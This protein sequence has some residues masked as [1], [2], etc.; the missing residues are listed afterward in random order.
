M[1]L[2]DPEK[3]CAVLIGASAYGDPGLNEL[4]AVTNNVTR[5]GELL[6]DHDVWGL[7][8]ERCIRVPEPK[9]LVELLDPIHEAARAATDTL[10]VYFAGH[11]LIHPTDINTLLLALPTT[12]PPRPYT[13]VDFAQ[14]R[15]VVRSSAPNVNR[16]V[17]LDCCYAGRAF[18]GGMNGS[19]DEV[20]LAQQARIG[21]RTCSPHAPPPG[22]L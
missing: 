5:L 10:F 12:N 19:S 21:G 13:A 6:M 1:K 7:P 18:D 4:P 16:L 9:T 17:V 11:G 22:K 20:I 14:V 15:A 3:S 2:A 8:E